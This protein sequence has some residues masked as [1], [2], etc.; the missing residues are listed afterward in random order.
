MNH[1]CIYCGVEGKLSKE[2]Y[3]PRCLGKFKG[4][5]RLNNRICRDCNGKL[6]QL[7][8]QFCRSG[9]EAGIRAALGIKGYKHHHQISPFHKGAAGAGRLELIGKSL[10]DGAESYLEW[11]DHPGAVRPR[12]EFVFI[13]E[14]GPVKVIISDDMKEPEDLLAKLH[15][16]GIREASSVV[17]HC[18]EDEKENMLLLLACLKN[19]MV[20]EPHYKIIPER[21]GKIIQKSNLT[22]KYIRGL[23]KIGFHYFLKHMGMFH[24]S[25]D[26]F[27]EIRS[28]ITKGNENVGQYVS[29]V[30]TYHTVEGFPPST[31]V[32]N[33]R[34]ILSAHISNQLLFARLQFFL[35]PG[36]T[37]PSYTINLGRRPA[38][39][40][41]P[42]IRNHA[43]I[44]SED[45]KQD[46]YDGL[47]VE[48][49][50]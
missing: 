47:M 27:K 6:S 11:D 8:E 44:Y 4:C 49:R 46:G 36:V 20:G 19:N 26:I 33:F 50:A 48:A 30:V 45:Y 37:L 41:W 5:E 16:L 24:G 1:R 39:V 3:L 10:K 42:Q 31:S 2:D 7:D 12:R 25:E 13:T 18:M 14:S 43:F 34:H 29:G 32:T 21:Q 9:P 22:D 40:N 15:E 38:S 23:A 35:G 28:F 17:I